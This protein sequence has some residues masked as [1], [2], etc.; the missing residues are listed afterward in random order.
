MRVLPKKWLRIVLPVAVL[1][2]ATA[3]CTGSDEATSTSTSAPSSSVPQTTATTTQPAPSTTSRPVTTQTTTTTTTSTTLPPAAMPTFEDDGETVAVDTGVRIGVLENGLTYYI[4][5]NTAPG[6]RAQLRLAVRAGSVH[7]VDDQR[8]AAHYLEHMMFNGTER[9]PAN[10]LIKVLSRFGAEFGPDI[11]AY[12]SYEET[13]Y[14]IELAT[15]ESET[16]ELGLDVLFEWATAVALDPEEVDLERGVLLE[17]WRLRDQGF[18]G[19]YR[20]GVVDHLLDGT[21]FENRDPLANPE[22][23]ETTTSEGLREFFDTWYRSERMAVIAVGDID[24]DVIEDLIIERFGAIEAGADPQSDPEFTI[25]PFFV[26]EYFIIA[27]PEFPEAWSELNYPIPVSGPPDTVGAVRRSFALSLAFDMLATRLRE[28]TLR[29]LTPF[30]ESGRASNDQLRAQRTPGVLAWAEPGNLSLTTET[31]L[32]EIKRARTFGFSQAELD[33]AVEETRSF[34]ELEFEER[35]TKQDWEYAAEYVENFLGG[36][37]IP[38]ADGELELL[39]RLLDEMTVDQVW[40]TFS[41]TIDSTE[42]FVIIV[43]PENASSEIPDEADLAVIVELVGAAA[44]APWVD[45]AVE[46]DA[47]MERPS[48]SSVLSRS[49]FSDTTIPEMT[50]SNGARIVMLQTQI[51]DDVV[52]MRVRS[53]GGWSIVPAE[54]VAE[55]QYAGSIAQLSGVGGIDQVSLERALSDQV[56]FAVP[57]V[58]EVHEGIFGEASGEDLE[59]LFQLVN[60]Y[61]TQAQFDEGPR[62]LVVSEQL[63]TAR[64][65]HLS[66]NL[67]VSSAIAEA[68]YSGDDRFA[69]RPSVEDFETFDLARA[70]EIYRERFGNPG[71]FV[72]VFVGDFDSDELEDLARR[73]IGS[74][75]SD[76][77]AEGFT[78][79]RPDPPAGL[80]QSVV[81]A[82]TGELGRV[83]LLFSSEVTL[84]P[85]LRVDI[86][87]LE[88]V[89]QQRLTDRI[90]E[91]LSASYSP[92][93]SVGLIEEPVD[94]VEFA[95]SVSA[96]PADL[97]AVASAALGEIEALRDDGPTEDELFIAQQ[98]LLRDYELFSNEGLAAEILFYAEHP[99]EMLTEILTRGDRVLAAT[100]S[101]LRAAALLLLPGDGYIDVRLVPIGFELEAA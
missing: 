90:R 32:L 60:L 41:A 75:P 77:D 88:L 83:T 67:A 98:Q 76:G 70:E 47:L 28:D 81:E 31:L 91:E 52:V 2:I 85:E 69:P 23:L 1:A 94:S 101:D 93:A 66:P 86:A 61:M 53:P 99:D 65:A 63:Q 13:V 30:F 80:V 50:L 49:A 46:V 74:I 3:A 17:E 14:E 92:F 16:V 64:N 54:D 8:G 37:S 100:R 44:V 58:S 82:G 29:G 57:F 26:P 79:T 12:T 40:Q 55:A 21:P 36:A 97:D 10:E 43:A 39:G 42:P 11:N 27:D 38:D 89:V 95:I 87:L 4:R 72:F 24:V 84:D 7:E 51:R 62:D 9:F 35:A 20:S 96:D 68:R 6:G 59:T 33:R 48:A 56:A 71:D 19:R 45:S 22:Q 15:E 34:V 5:R 25:D 78:D 18:F 73:Y